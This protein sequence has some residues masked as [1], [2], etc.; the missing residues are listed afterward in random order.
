MEIL[1]RLCTIEKDARDCYYE[2]TYVNRTGEMVS[3]F[4]FENSKL[5]G[6]VRRQH[7]DWFG[8]KNV[9]VKP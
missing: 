3:S 8:R 4:G 5:H 1:D 2:L 7:I 6:Y 9:F